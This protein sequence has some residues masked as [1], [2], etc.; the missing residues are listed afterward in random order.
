MLSNSS[1]YIDE[2]TTNSRTPN[3]RNGCTTLETY[4]RNKGSPNADRDRRM[5]MAS[6]AIDLR[7]FTID[8]LPKAA[9]LGRTRLQANGSYVSTG[10]TE[11]DE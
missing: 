8:Y 1:V 3:N 2:E 6:L 10:C 4:P 11:E 5:N 9:S 7:P